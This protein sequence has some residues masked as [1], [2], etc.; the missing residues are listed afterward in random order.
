MKF[1]VVSR[2]QR[3]WNQFSAREQQQLTVAF[4]VIISVSTLILGFLQVRHLLNRP[5]YY[6]TQV[7]VN[8]YVQPFTEE[9]EQ[10]SQ[11]VESQNKDT[12]EDGLNDYEELYVYSSSPY[13]A[14]TDSDGFSDKQEVDSNH[15]PNCPA[16]ENCLGGTTEGAS[17]LDSAILT[18]PDDLRVALMNY[19]YSQEQVA[20][21]SDEQLRAAYV[22][23]ITS[24]Q[25][26]AEPSQADQLRSAILQAGIVDEET[27]NT[28]SDEEII[29]I[30][31]ETIGGEAGAAEGS[32]PA[33]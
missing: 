25:P 13:I 28:L 15:N 6:F 24:E 16:S 22:A 31:S 17:E 4:L 29:R 20:A 21:M 1:A 27:L 2:L 26:I 14:D 8:S 23:I 19:G 9:E 18:N 5:F 11:V 10:L 33:P 7:D 30:Y 12:D 3:F 32:A